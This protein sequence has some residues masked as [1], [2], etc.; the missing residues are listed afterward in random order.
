ML[1]KYILFLG[2]LL[3]SLTSFSYGFEQLIQGEIDG[4]KFTIIK[5][6]LDGEHEI[7]TA[8]NANGKAT[9]L[10]E[11][12]ER[13]WGISAVNGAYFCPSESTY[14]RCGA[15]DTTTADRYY[16]GNI[17]SKYHPDTGWRWIF[18]FTK[19]GAFLFVQNNLG[20]VPW[21]MNNTNSSRLQDIYYWISNFPILIDKGKIINL[22][23]YKTDIDAKMKATGSKTFICANQDGT[24]ISLWS[25]ENITMY[26]MWPFLSKNFWCRYAINRD[27]WTSKG[28]IFNK[29]YIG[30]AGRDIM[31]AFIIK[32]IID[33]YE[34]QQEREKL[35]QAITWMFENG[36]TIFPTPETFGAENMITREQVAKFL[37]EFAVQ[38]YPRDQVANITCSFN[39][40]KIA[41]R[42]LLEHIQTSCRLWLFKWYNNQF[43]PTNPISN[44]EVLAVVT[45]IINPSIQQSTPWHRAKN[46]RDYIK[47]QEWMDSLSMNDWIN[48]EKDA[49]RWEIA[50]LLYASRH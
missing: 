26:E 25:V 4:K 49:T 10:N 11:L 27:S 34:L 13:E 7:V 29:E 12:M 38:N 48:I 21:P 5:V 3:A 1:N 28:M 50:L 47:T 2:M 41:D 20:Y 8:V 15:W 32:E 24:H 17:Y 36:Y 30:E 19:T 35:Q 9:S 6:I 37:T 23:V 33:P 18:W 40:L 44:A 31:D 46:Y 16:Q 43:F 42:T 45:R 22:D 14:D 39:D